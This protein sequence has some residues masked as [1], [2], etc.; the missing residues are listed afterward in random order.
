M[1][2]PSTTEDVAAVVGEPVE[3]PAAAV[4]PSLAEQNA[5]ADRA[6]GRTAVQVGVP[7]AL[8]GIGSWAARLA[9][10]D[11]DPGPGVDLPADV[12]GYFVAVVTV[13]LAFA[14][15]RKR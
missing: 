3:P 9:G 14:M 11:L 6:R 7:A 12:A 1:S 10:I 2:E 5:T 13:G 8:V 15:N 4:V